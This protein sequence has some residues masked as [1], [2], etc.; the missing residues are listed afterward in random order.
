MNSTAKYRLDE[1]PPI[2]R[3]VLVAEDSPVTQ[4]LLK[5]I[6]TQRGHEVDIADD[7]EQALSALRKH[8]Y[9]VALIDF[10]LPKLDGLQVAQQY[11]GEKNGDA[12]ARLIAITADVEGLLS[13]KEN[14]ENFDQI[15]PKP[16]DIYE[17]CNVIEKAAA[18]GPGRKRQP[19]PARPRRRPGGAQTVSPATARHRAQV[20]EPGWA[21]GLELLRWPEDFDPVA[22]HGRRLSCRHGRSDHRRHPDQRRRPGWP[23]SG[24][25]GSA[26][27]SIFSRS[28]IWAGQLGAHADLDASHSHYASSEAVRGLVQSFHQRRGELH[29]D[30]TMTADLGEKLLGRMFVS[31]ASW[32]PPMTQAKRR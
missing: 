16:L 10:R 21:T 11:R 22:L 3:R 28:S 32:A 17:I 15:I 9:D 26:S 7:G 20:P 31:N 27:S 19:N 8:A 29:R 5:L 24:R 14:C 1:L 25:S 13:H 23:I 2:Y 6:L 4:D 18:R 30:L 12:Q